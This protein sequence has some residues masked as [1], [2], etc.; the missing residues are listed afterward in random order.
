LSEFLQ[1]ALQLFLI[2]K[3]IK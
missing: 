1:T 3:L 2:H